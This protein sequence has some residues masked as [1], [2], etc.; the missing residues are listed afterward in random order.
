MLMIGTF[1]ISD[2]ERKFL[3]TLL[4]AFRMPILETIC[5]RPY[6][7]RKRIKTHLG[8]LD[9]TGERIVRDHI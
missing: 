6:S 1:F 3:K 4:Q 5:Q 2:L 8:D 9:R 7:N